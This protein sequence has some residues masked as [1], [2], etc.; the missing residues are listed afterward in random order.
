MKSTLTISSI[1]LGFF[2]T[3]LVQIIN[4]KNKYSNDA[5]SS[6]NVFFKNVSGCEMTVVLVINVLNTVILDVISLLILI[7]GENVGSNYL[8]LWGVIFA[9]FI[10]HQCYVYYIFIE[11]FLMKEKCSGTHGKLTTEQETKFNA[12]ISKN[13]LEQNTFKINNQIKRND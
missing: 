6:I 11:L 13:T 3:L 4:L 7:Q 8:R 10:F 2:G 1:L 5:S 12:K 9:I